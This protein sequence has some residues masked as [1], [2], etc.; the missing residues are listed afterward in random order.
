MSET[1]NTVVD[2]K[3]TP[4]T[5]TEEPKAEPT[6]DNGTPPESDT[7]AKTYETALRKVLGMKDG[8]EFGDIDKRIADL[9]KRNSEIE[10]NAKN[11]IISYAIKAL[12]GYDTKLLNKVIDLTNVSIDEKGNVTG[13]DEAVKAAAAEFPAVVLKKEAKEPF[14]PV[15]P[16][17]AISESVTMNDLI[18]GKLK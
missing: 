5:T 15:N 6:A 8:E 16:S 9:E 12:N 7:Q 2:E 3:G 14:K 11:S 10:Q 4:P 18:R 13:L 1:Q 17:G